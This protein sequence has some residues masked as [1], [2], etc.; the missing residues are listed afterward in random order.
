MGGVWIALKYRV[1]CKNLHCLCMQIMRWGVPFRL[2]GLCP[3]TPARGLP[4]PGPLPPL[5]T[6]LTMSEMVSV[7]PSVC[8]SVT[9]CGGTLIWVSLLQRGDPALKKGKDPNGGCLDRP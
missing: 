6:N 1:F 2:R 5:S 4:P 9:P 3:R 8:P 7:R